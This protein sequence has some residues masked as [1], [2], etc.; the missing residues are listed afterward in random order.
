MGASYRH[1]VAVT[2]ALGAA[3]PWAIWYLL[4]GLVRRLGGGINHPAVGTQPLPRSRRAL[5]WLMVVVFVAIFMPVPFRETITGDAAQPDATTA[6][7][8]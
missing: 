7:N 1:D 3:T 6:V 5:F 2:N 8:P 4:V